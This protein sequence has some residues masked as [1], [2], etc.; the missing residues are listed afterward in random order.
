MRFGY[1][2]L[3]A[4]LACT[5]SACSSLVTAPTAF[6]IFD[7]GEPGAIADNDRVSPAHVEVRGP[8]WL[9]SSAMQ[10]RLDYQV[11]A[12]REAFTESR[13]AGQPAEMLQRLLAAP[14]IGDRKNSGGCRLRIEL[15]EFV[16]VFDSAQSS[17]A[18]VL[19]RVALLP[20]RGE[21]ALAREYFS[22]R[23]SAPGA[24]AAAGVQAHREAAR[25]LVGSLAEW[26]GVTR[27]GPD[28]TR[29]CRR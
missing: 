3:L 10:Y 12:R 1:R 17:H 25:E 14:L 21:A 29:E 6:S 26:L 23:V 13:W 19:A 28:T 24:D 4:F 22:V 16:Q 15:D 2:S 18:R 8:S 9:A 20:P 27:Q 5:L 11:P 7:L